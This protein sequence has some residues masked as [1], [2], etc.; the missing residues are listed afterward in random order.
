MAKD[1][2][3]PA[4]TTSAT[5]LTV[6]FLH[7][8]RRWRRRWLDGRIGFSGQKSI[9]GIRK[10]KRWHRDKASEANS[11]MKAVVRKRNVRELIMGRC[12]KCGV[13]NST[14]HPINAFRDATN[15]PMSGVFRERW[16]QWKV[17]Q[18]S[19]D[20]KRSGPQQRLHVHVPRGNDDDTVKK[21]KYTVD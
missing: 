2:D 10:E 21:Q 18:Q 13:E 4:A 15:V 6:H 7:L 11:E 9:L 1:D 3:W 20:H 17:K 8:R 19:R 14:V 16:K 5:T 12:F